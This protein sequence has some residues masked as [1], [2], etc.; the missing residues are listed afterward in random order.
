MEQYI[1]KLH[2]DTDRTLGLRHVSAIP[3]K[4]RSG[5]LCVDD[6]TVRVW[7]ISGLRKGSP[8]VGG[9]PGNFETFDS[10]ST[11]KYVLEGHNRGVNFAMF[12]PTLPPTISAAPPMIGSSRFGV[13]SLVIST[14]SPVLSFTQSTS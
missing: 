13:L 8:N 11:V 4:R 3:S 1:K 6:Q 2:S 9:G 12:H 10:F 7:D 5:C 14:T